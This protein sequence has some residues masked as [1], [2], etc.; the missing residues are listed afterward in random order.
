MDVSVPKQGAA[1][2]LVFFVL[3]AV[4]LVAPQASEAWQ[5]Q[6][7]SSSAAATSRRA[8]F[9]DG[10]GKALV[11]GG[12]FVAAAT[13]ASP[14]AANAID[15]TSSKLASP[16]A[17]RSVKS[18]LRK[19]STLDGLVS[20]GGY[21]EIREALRVPPVSDLRK[22][23]ATIIYGSGGDINDP[24]Q[25]LTGGYKSVVASLEKMD[26]LAGLGARGR[27]IPQSEL[28]AALD[29]T[30]SSLNEFVK[31]AEGT[32]NVSQASPASSSA[33][34]EG[35]PAAAAATSAEGSS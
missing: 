18:S 5:Q 29:G 26:S 3:A 16:G 28:A 23:C 4:A 12:G 25:E 32:L 6:Q 24:G 9:S 13:A 8:F 33:S 20:D 27:T 31:L 15:V 35:T 14:K 2:L 7:P 22:S 30:K 19:M 1:R 21:A 10:A 17:L 34:S 11:L